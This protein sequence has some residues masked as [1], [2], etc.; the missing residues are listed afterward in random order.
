MA[1]SRYRVHRFDT[2]MSVDRDDL[3]RALNGIAGEIVAIV[4]NVMQFPFARVN[5]LLVVERVPAV[6]D[7]PPAMP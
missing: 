3:E 7:E 5:Y 6:P 1:T 2:G 4:P